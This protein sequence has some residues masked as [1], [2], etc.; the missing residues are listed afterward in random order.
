M[1][2]CERVLVIHEGPQGWQEGWGRNGKIKKTCE[3][4]EEEETVT[5]LLSL[6]HT[7][8]AFIEEQIF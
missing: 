4:G 8:I 2:T 5:V 7:L 3:E 6:L 1:M